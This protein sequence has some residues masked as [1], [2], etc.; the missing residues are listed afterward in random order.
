MV[1]P[2]VEVG[3]RYCS[4]SPLSFRGEGLSLIVT[5][6]GYNDLVSMFV[7]SSCG[8]RCQLTLFLGLFFYFCYLLSLL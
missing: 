1:S 5:G 4:H 7:Y 6:G 8:C 3:C 2:E